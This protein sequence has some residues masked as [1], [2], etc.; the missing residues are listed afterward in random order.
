MIKSKCLLIFGF[1]FSNVLLSQKTELIY[2]SK[3]NSIFSKEH[4]A[5]T[6][7]GLIIE[8][9]IIM[10]ETLPYNPTSNRRLGFEA[11]VEYY[12]NFN[13]NFSLNTGI[14]L[15]HL[16]RNFGFTIPKAYLP[17]RFTEDLVIDGR[18]SRIFPILYV[19]IPLSFEKRYFIKSNFLYYGA[20]LNFRYA[21]MQDYN[22]VG[23][24]IDNNAPN[25]ELEENWIEQNKL[26][27]QPIINF[28]YGHILKNN[29]LLKIGITANFGLT[30]IKATNYFFYS[31]NG[32]SQSGEYITRGGYVGLAVS[33]VF[34]GLLKKT[35]K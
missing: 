28:G 8:K 4:L 34:S 25:M 24:F 19:S 12:I 32:P 17:A 20:G 11:G 14:L 2:A 21:L 27:V 23:H 22:S 9:G 35:I 33:Y 30:Q 29:N 18:F 6:G 16:P 7:K 1:L 13:K 26:N 5:F 15:G 3:I 31:N 10:G